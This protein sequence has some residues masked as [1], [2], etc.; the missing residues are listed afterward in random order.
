MQLGAIDD[1]AN[2]GVVF[3]DNTR[4]RFEVIRSGVVLIRISLVSNRKIFK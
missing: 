2:S 1:G 4:S 3:E